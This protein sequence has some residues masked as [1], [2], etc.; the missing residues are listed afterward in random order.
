MRTVFRTIF[1]VCIIELLFFFFYLC[2]GNRSKY[3]FTDDDLSRQLVAFFM[4]ATPLALIGTLFGLLKDTDSSRK[5]LTVIVTMVVFA[6]LVGLVLTGVSLVSEPTEIAMRR[7]L[8]VN[9]GDSTWRIIEQR[10]RPNGFG[11]G[12]IRILETKPMGSWFTIYK[13]VDTSLLN[14]EAWIPFKE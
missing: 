10:E 6:F 7:T 4:A 1:V 3:Y 8:L 14:H 12:G 11:S 9:K 5:Q 13:D 2:Y